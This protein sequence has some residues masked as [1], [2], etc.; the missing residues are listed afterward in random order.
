VW[1]V[2]CCFFLGFRDLN[3]RCRH[4][5]VELWTPEGKER[6][7]R[8]ECLVR[9]NQLLRVGMVAMWTYGCDFLLLRFLTWFDDV[10][11]IIFYL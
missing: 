4:V 7:V 6:H 1:D 2:S 3:I 10:F 11:K 8:K 5:D 9:G